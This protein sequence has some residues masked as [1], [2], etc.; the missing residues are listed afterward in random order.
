MKK[1][2]SICLLFMLFVCALSF[3]SAC[4][5]DDYPSNMYWCQKVD[6]SLTVSSDTVYANEY[7]TALK[8]IFLR[9]KFSLN[10]QQSVTDSIAKK[11][12]NAAMAAGD[13]VA[14]TLTHTSG[15]F[16]YKLWSD[17]TILLTSHRIVFTS[18]SLN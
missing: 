12:F 11:V 9:G 16:D 18:T 13:S 1:L 2:P 17:S 8:A 7:K 3:F 10:G 4:A 6:S 5:T 14:N 15:Y